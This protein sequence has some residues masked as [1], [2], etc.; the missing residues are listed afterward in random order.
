[1]KALLAFLLAAA[2]AVAIYF[3]LTPQNRRIQ[4][5]SSSSSSSEPS[6]ETTNHNG[7]HV[8]LDVGDIK[9][10]LEKSGKVIRRNLEKAGQAVADATSD[11]RIKT[12][13]KA[14]LIADPKLSA[15]SIAV[16]STDGIVTLSGSVSAY[17]DISRAMR[18][19]L[20]TDG[21]RE[22]NSTLQ[23]HP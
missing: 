5:S 17:D 19:A 6:S 20:E 3:Y 22:V 10:E 9:T 13:I 8:S 18:I 16:N 2:V 15:L 12:A 1:M 7:I 21:V 4:F 11:V 14:K 23:V